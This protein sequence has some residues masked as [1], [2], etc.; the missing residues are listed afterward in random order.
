MASD[1]SAAMHL[2]ADT[3]ISR[4]I[5]Y[6]AQGTLEL[7]VYF[8]DSA[9]ALE[10]QAAYC[11]TLCKAAP[12]SLIVQEDG[13]ILAFDAA[14]V[15]KETGLQLQSGWNRLSFTLDLSADRAVLQVNDGGSSALPVIAEAGRYICAVRLE[16]ENQDIFVDRF[17]VC[18]AACTANAHWTQTQLEVAFDAR[19][20]TAVA[21]Q[22]VEY[23]QEA[24]RPTD[25]VKPG[26]TFVEWQ[27]DGVRYDFETPVTKNITLTAVWKNSNPSIAGTAKNGTI[28]ANGLTINREFSWGMSIELT[29]T[30]D[31][32]Y[33][34]SDVRINGRSIGAVNSY[35]IV[36]L[37]EEVTVDL[38]CIRDEDDT[39]NPYVFP[40]VDVKTDDWYY[41]SVKAAHQMGLIDGMTDTAFGPD[42][43]MT[44]AQAITLAARMYASTTDDRLENG[45]YPY[46]YSTYVD[47]CLEKGIIDH[48]PAAAALNA[49][50]TRAEYAAIFARALP[51]GYLP[52]I[53]I[54]PDNSI[55]DVKMGDKNADA[56]YLLYRAGILDGRDDDGRFDPDETIQRSEIAAILV[57]MMDTSYRV[58]APPK[59]GK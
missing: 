11:S 50:V 33:K 18:D 13:R 2:E 4:T 59:L 44:L 48:K 46:W 20:G 34:I 32:G 41:E 39:E 49:P 36:S 25:P 27:L 53:N 54:I 26:Y 15:M 21:S 37:Q 12:V 30:P 1:G 38:L 29:F 45:A 3:A 8:D 17:I 51:A 28:L 24:E 9:F 16:T 56:I 10:L 22:T 31:P 47:Y 58:P 7:D 19:G 52:A 42:D 43:E 40:F 55:P 6:L 35:K 5:P 23:Q 57:R 14:G